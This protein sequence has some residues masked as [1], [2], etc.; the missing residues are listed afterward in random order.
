MAWLALAVAL[1]LLAVRVERYRPRADLTGLAG[2]AGLAVILPSSLSVYD[3]RIVAKC[4]GLGL[5]AVAAMFWLPESLRSRRLRL[6]SLVCGWA[7]GLF[8]VLGPSEGLF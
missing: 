3:D 5:V 2:L 6:V 8:S 1:L 7:A 4:V